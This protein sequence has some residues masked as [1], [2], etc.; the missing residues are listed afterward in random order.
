MKRRG[1]PRFAAMA[2]PYWNSE[3]KWIA[4]G[5]LV[6]LIVLLLGNTAF[7]VLLFEQ[8]S[9]FTSAL[10]SQDPNHYWVAS[11]KTVGII[12]V[13]A[14][15]YVFDDYVRDKLVNYWRRWL[16][17][18]FLDMYFRSTAIYK[19]AFNADIHRLSVVKYHGHVL[20]LGGVGAWSVTLA[21]DSV[22][23]STS[24]AVVRSK[25]PL[26]AASD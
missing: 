18:N 13:A 5:L 20:D 16:T 17:H 10:A 14:P 12:V 25:R 4:R 19:L 7:R 26:I 22:V 3:D 15:F 1:L 24:G 23:G 8:S 6:L 11:Y 2:K 21:E 9:E